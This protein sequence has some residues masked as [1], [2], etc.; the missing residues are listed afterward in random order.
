MAFEDLNI[1]NSEWEVYHN[2]DGLLV[3]I[4]DDYPSPENTFDV[5]SGVDDG[6]AP[7]TTP[8]ADNKRQ[9]VDPE[10]L[11]G[12][13]TTA[14]SVGSQLY[15]NRDTSKR[16]LK[17]VCGG[18]PFCIG[19]GRCRDKKDKY[20]ACKKEFYMGSGGFKSGGTQTQQQMPVYTPPTPPRGMSTTAKVGIA[21]GIVALGVGGYFI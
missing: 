12:A 17:N 3:P 15:A 19:K 11:A 10:L 5:W 9:G 7:A 21:L 6:K 13:L 4:M 2:S 1:N 8:P 20:E 18:K 14:V 16:E